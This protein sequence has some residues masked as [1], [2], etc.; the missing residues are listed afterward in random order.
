MQPFGARFGALTPA[1]SGER[2]ATFY[3]F[4]KISA[5]LI[6]GR[7]TQQPTVWH[8]C[9]NVLENMKDL[10]QRQPEIRTYPF[11]SQRCR[12]PNVAQPFPSR[13]CEW[14]SAYLCITRQ[15]RASQDKT[16]TWHSSIGEGWD[17]RG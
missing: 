4:R 9:G 7:M 11:I 8:R 16:S 12:N 10:C 15:P 6:Y 1:R 17:A 14:T 5:S 13:L 2:Q 3:F